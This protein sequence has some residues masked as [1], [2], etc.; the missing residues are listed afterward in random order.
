MSTTINLIN[1]EQI[2]VNN[3]TVSHDSSKFISNETIRQSIPTKDIYKISYNNRILGF[4]KGD[5]WGGALGGAY[6]LT[7]TEYSSILSSYFISV[8]HNTVRL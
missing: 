1:G 3:F 5:F 6:L 7:K 4:S 8:T 2:S